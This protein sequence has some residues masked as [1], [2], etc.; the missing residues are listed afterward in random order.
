MSITKEEA[1]AMVQAAVTAATA[2]LRSEIENLKTVTKPADPKPAEPPKTYTR[3]ELEAAVGREEITK[4]QAQ[5]IWDAQQER[6]TRQLIAEGVQS[7]VSATTKTQT[8]KQRVEAYKDL[9]PGLMEDGSSDRERVRKR[10]NQLLERGHPKN[11]ETELLALELTYGEIEGLRATKGARSEVETHEETGGGGSLRR[12]RG[13]EETPA[14]LKLSAG[15]RTYYED[16]MAKGHYPGGW[17]DVK[18]ELAFAP[19]RPSS[20]AMH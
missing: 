20:R 17:K 18:A 16:L 7:A 6:I 2:P 3:A 8:T 5:D 12:S 1:E 14:G 9:I 10:V 11:H 13:G 4:V 15:Q 19:K